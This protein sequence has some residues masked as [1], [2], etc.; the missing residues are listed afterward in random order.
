MENNSDSFSWMIW[1][2]L[3]LKAHL[4]TLGYAPESF[5]TMTSLKNIVLKTFNDLLALF[6]K[7]AWLKSVVLKERLTIPNYLLRHPVWIHFVIPTAN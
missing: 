2:S 1:K 5:R 6:R 3:V 4:G 7:G